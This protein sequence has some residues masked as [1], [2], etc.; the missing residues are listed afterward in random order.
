[1]D[2]IFSGLLGGGG[3]V[4]GKAKLEKVDH[5]A[6]AFEGF[7]LALAPLCLVFL[8]PGCHDGN[9]SDPPHPSAMMLCLTT[10]PETMEPANHGLK[11][12]KP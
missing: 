9:S 5:W 6:S 3:T 2:S 12:L 11:S 4:E 1:M 7:I 8:L 10:G